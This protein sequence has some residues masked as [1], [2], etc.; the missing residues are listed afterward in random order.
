MTPIQTQIEQIQSLAVRHY[1]EDEALRNAWLVE[2]LT[3]RIRE[4]AAMFQPLKVR[5]MSDGTSL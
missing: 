5:E 2:K 3:E 1:P 4:L